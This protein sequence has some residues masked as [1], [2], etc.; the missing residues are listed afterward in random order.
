MSSPLHC[1]TLT[2][3]LCPAIHSSCL[4]ATASQTRTVPS[5]DADANF[6]QGA[7]RC[8]GCQAMHVIHFVCPRQLPAHAEFDACQIHTAP[9]LSPVASMVA[10]GDQEHA[11]THARCKVPSLYGVCVFKSQNRTVV[12]PEP[13]AKCFPSGLKC[14][15]RTASLWPAQLRGT[16]LGMHACCSCQK[17]PQTTANH[18][19]LCV[20]GWADMTWTAMPRQTTAIVAAKSE[21]AGFGSWISP[22]IVAEHR[23]TGLTR[24]TACGR[25]T[26]CTTCS[27][28]TL[29]FIIDDPMSPESSKSSM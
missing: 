22:S 8:R 4:R 19:S 3:L 28:D 7:V 6:R 1:T 20:H 13:L 2:V 24:N 17:Q 9:S 16:W 29:F 26:T 11:I 21:D 5:L 27:T 10:S 25:Y 12:S 23:A 14:T 15:D 18:G